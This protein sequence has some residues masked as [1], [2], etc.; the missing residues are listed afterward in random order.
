E[1]GVS[2]ADQSGTATSTITVT[3]VGDTPRVADITTLE[4]TPSGPIVINRHAA[5]GAEVTHFRISGIT[6]G[7]LFKNDGATPINNG[8]FITFAEAQAGVKFLPATD[9]N[10]V[11]QFS[12]ESSENGVSVAVQSGMATSTITVTPVG[13][14]PQVA[15]I[16]TLEDVLSGPIVIDRAAVDGPEVTHFRISGIIGGTLFK[17]DG[18]APIADGAFITFAEAQAGVRFLPAPDSNATGQFQVSSSENGTSVAAQSGQALSTITVTPVVDAPRI[19]V[20]SSA[21][22]VVG[23]ESVV[24]DWHA[25]LLHPDAG[26][27]ASATV[28]ITGNFEAATDVLTAVA[29]PTV[30]VVSSDGGRTLTLLPE[31]GESPSPADFQAVLRTA[32]YQNSSA[33]PANVADRLV[34]FSVDDGSGGPMA[35]GEDVLSVE[36]VVP[37]KF[38]NLP[39]RFDVD[40]SGEADF[41]DIL[42]L[43]HDLRSYG[44]HPVGSAG[45]AAPPPFVDVN[46][47]GTVNFIDILDVIAHL[48]AQSAASG[49]GESTGGA[50]VEFVSLATKGDVRVEFSSESTRAA[51]SQRLVADPSESA[52]YVMSRWTAS[53]SPNLAPHRSLVP[54]RDTALQEYLHDRSFPDRID[55]HA[56]DPT[57][58]IEEDDFVVAVDAI[59]S[60]VEQQEASAG[61]RDRVFADFDA[62]MTLNTARADDLDANW[63]RRKSSD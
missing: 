41:T 50:A 15:N 19:E 47:D 7:T 59:T 1:D 52:L 36:I 31:D 30:R 29:S 63:F 5:D 37:T 42:A 60:G 20:V 8:A 62:D 22:Y 25:S 24:L 2:V 12:V 35:V 28:S 57:S 58:I 56:W 53:L 43:I 45:P 17:N 10:A 27:I 32:A 40:N 4:D 16:T 38:T 34:T 21:R 61:A 14:T 9:S 44:L 6:G 26:P 39:N 51:S 18:I 23:G 3:P 55:S 48:R 46:G 33:N 54:P 49:E 11:G 13:D